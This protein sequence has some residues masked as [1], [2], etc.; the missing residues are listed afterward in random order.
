[1]LQNHSA[2]GGI[3]LHIAYLELSLP[4][5]LEKIEYFNTC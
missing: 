3:N 2:F 5:K 4:I 1:M